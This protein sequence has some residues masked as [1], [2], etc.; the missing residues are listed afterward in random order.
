MAGGIRLCSKE[1]RWQTVH[2]VTTA[3]KTD[4]GKEEN[5]AES[6]A[7]QASCVA[8]SQLTTPFRFRK[9]LIGRQSPDDKDF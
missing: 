4:F 2:G 1:H 6:K 7:L 9:A 8:G 5:E 3:S